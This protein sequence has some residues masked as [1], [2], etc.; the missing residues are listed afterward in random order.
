MAKIVYQFVSS[1]LFGL[2]WA[3]HAFTTHSNTIHAECVEMFNAG[4][5]DGQDAMLSTSRGV[6]SSQ[7]C[8]QKQVSR[9]EQGKK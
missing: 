5:G 1:C 4:Q 8:Q 9:I 3:L 7:T 2:K 6:W